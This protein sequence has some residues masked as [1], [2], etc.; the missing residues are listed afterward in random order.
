MYMA[1]FDVQIGV[2]IENNVGY[3]GSLLIK[4][5]VWSLWVLIIIYYLERA[6][7]RLFHGILPVCHI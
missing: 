4:H 1:V 3:S 5:Y 6:F 7:K 2:E